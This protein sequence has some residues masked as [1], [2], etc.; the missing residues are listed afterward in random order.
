MKGLTGELLTEHGIFPAVVSYYKSKW[1]NYRTPCHAHDRMEI[2]YVTEGH[3]TV[4]ADGKP[5]LLNP[6]SYILL[7]AGTPH[8][9]CIGSSCAVLNVEMI[10]RPGAFIGADV[11]ALAAQEPAVRHLGE[12]D[13]PYYLLKDDGTVL[14]TL[15]NLY[16]V[17][18][19]NRPEEPE[20]VLLLDYLLIRLAKAVRDTDRSPSSGYGYVENACRYI[21]SHIN[22]TIKVSDIAASVPINAAY[23]QR[24]FK[25]IKGQTLISY[26]NQQRM[27]LACQLLTRTDL[28]IAELALSLGF[29]SQQYFSTLFKQVV[30]I[31][32]RQYRRTHGSAADRSRRIAY[33]D[34]REFLDGLTEQ[35]E[36]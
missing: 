3:C 9:L 20:T 11:A 4:T 31:S 1:E 29:G 2:M 16:E 26:I 24:L 12:A 33:T 5:V 17:L 10:F 13:R 19:I 27:A 36:D 18:D 28:D 35:K 32:P 34:R 25:K 30:G 7:D 22:E 15:L 21:R 8:D 23:L 6:F 14:R